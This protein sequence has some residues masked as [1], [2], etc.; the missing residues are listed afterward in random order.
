MVAIIIFECV[1][2]CAAKRILKRVKEI[3]SFFTRDEKKKNRVGNLEKSKTSSPKS[4]YENSSFPHTIL[5]NNIV[6]V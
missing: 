5:K 6:L 3:K 1:T 2:K 4:A